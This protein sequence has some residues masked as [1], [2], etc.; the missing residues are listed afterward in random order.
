MT[1]S[2]EPILDALEAHY[3]PQVPLA[4]TDPYQFLVWWHC[5]Y[6]PGEAR[7]EQGWQAL[8][9][10]I[11]I[12]PQVLRAARPARLARVL[13]RRRARPAAAR[14]T[15]A[16]GRNPRARG[17]R[18][19]SGRG[20]RPCCRRR[21]RTPRCANFPASGRP[22]PIAYC[23]S[24]GSHRSPQFPR[25]ARTCCRAS[26]AAASPSYRASYVPGATRHRRRHPACRRAAPAHLPAAA[27]A[28]PRAVQA[29]SSTV[30]AVPAGAA[31]P[32]QPGGWSPENFTA[33]APLIG[34]TVAWSLT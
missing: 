34:P 29:H 8:R 3:G 27:A 22:A 31:L 7:C 28:R 16:R 10:E 14:R 1:P 26:L 19:R 11:A 13:G 15:S 23:C 25:A 12:D 17:F 9:R 21:R 24:Q 6:P 33:V 4:P 5:G 18:R 2:L 30:P 32:L 20:A